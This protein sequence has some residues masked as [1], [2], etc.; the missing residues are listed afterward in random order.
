M[1]NGTRCTWLVVRCFHILYIASNGQCTSSKSEKIAKY[2]VKIFSIG[3]SA[4][5]RVW[6]VFILFENS[7]VKLDIV[8]G[9]VNPLYGH[10]AAR[11]H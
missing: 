5:G 3:H 9:G 1:R 10:R 7:I 4:K 2:F 6:W 8:G 11:F